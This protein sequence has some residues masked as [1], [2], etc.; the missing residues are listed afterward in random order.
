MSYNN[1][2]GVG[3]F[4]RAL[5]SA[6]S[7]SWVKEYLLDP[8]EYSNSMARVTWNVTNRSGLFVDSSMLFTRTLMR[9]LCLSKSNA[10]L[11]CSGGA[12]INGSPVRQQTEV[13]TSR[14][15]N[16][17]QNPTGTYNVI[18]VK[19]K[20]SKFDKVC[21]TMDN[22]AKHDPRRRHGMD[23]QAGAGAPAPLG[24][25]QSHKTLHLP[26]TTYTTEGVPTAG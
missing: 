6:V 18:T 16:T 26:Y 19:R 24:C 13:F 25:A 20:R 22:L 15:N 9:R 12:S 10:I 7:G 3:Y 14:N 2:V 5:S 17:R 23:A 1:T 8:V 4:A 11:V 21:Q